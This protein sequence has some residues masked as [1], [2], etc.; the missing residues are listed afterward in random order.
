VP[1][2]RQTLLLL[3]RHA[4]RDVLQ[5]L[6]HGAANRHMAETKMN[7]ESSRS[8]CVFTC[9]VESKTTEDGMVNIRTSC[10]NLV[11]LAGGWGGA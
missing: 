9:V 8:H 4:V 6:S 1:G 5:L 2:A 7:K 11:D 10:L 3:R